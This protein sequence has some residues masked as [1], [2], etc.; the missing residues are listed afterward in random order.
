MNEL[1][2][3]FLNS[4]RTIS[5]EE[6][7]NLKLIKI[8]FDR[9]VESAQDKVFRLNDFTEIL[10]VCLINENTAVKMEKLLKDVPNLQ[11]EEYCELLLAVYEKKNEKDNWLKTAQKY[12]Q[13]NENVAEKLLHHYAEQKEKLTQLAQNIA[14]SLKN[15]FI[16]FFYEHLKK[17]DAEDI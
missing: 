12:Y 3:D 4:F 7:V 6:K 13:T 17:V 15:K 9:L 1:R 8:Y 14:F 10:L 11:E 5:L 2:R 16:P